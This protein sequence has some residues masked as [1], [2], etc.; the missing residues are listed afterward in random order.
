MYARPKVVGALPS[1]S[2]QLQIIPWIESRSPDTLK[3]KPGMSKMKKVYMLGVESTMPK[4]KVCL[5]VL[6]S[7]MS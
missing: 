2:R 5:T 3:N 7:L 4:Y 1:S 6:L